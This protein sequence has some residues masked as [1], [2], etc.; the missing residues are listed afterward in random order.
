MQ[1]KDSCYAKF[2]RLVHTKKQVS[3]P[4]ANNIDLHSG[5][6]SLAIHATPMDI[7]GAKAKQ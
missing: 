4:F 2:A 3:Y 7:R 1:K 6:R 5:A